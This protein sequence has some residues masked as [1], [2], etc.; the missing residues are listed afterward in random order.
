MPISLKNRDQNRPW[1]LKEWVQGKP[2]GHPS[3]PMFVHFP[4][5]FYLATLVFDVMTRIEANPGLVQAGT[6]LLVGAAV[7]TVILVITGLVDYLSMV[8]G[9]SKRK[10]GTRHLIANLV[11]AGFFLTSLVLRW[12][13]RTAAQADTLWIVL[14]AIGFSVISVAQYFGGVL[15]Y[16]K[17]M[18]VSTAAAREPDER[19][20]AARA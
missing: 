10:I 5:A 18:R 19:P 3:H 7:A 6:F 13:D 2:I 16:E 14:E 17:G 11:A 20:Q 9:S 12:P 15:V 4:I 8:P 1:S